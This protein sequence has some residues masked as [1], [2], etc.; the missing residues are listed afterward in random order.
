MLLFFCWYYILVIQQT[1]YKQELNNT[2]LNRATLNNG[3]QLVKKNFEITFKFKM[4]KSN[5]E[6][7]QIITNTLIKK[8]C[9]SIKYK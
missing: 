2:D 3:A 6:Q 7:E 8:N 4:Y 9:L 1:I 5:S